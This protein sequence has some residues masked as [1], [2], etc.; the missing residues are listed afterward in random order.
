MSA[1]GGSW[2]MSNVKKKRTKREGNDDHNPE[3]IAE[4]REENGAKPA[5]NRKT[6]CPSKNIGGGAE[7]I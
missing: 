2:E 5:V 3:P 4:Q 6:L 1:G 7:K